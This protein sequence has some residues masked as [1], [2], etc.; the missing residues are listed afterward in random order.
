[1][2]QISSS[3]KWPR[4]KKCAL[5]LSL[6]IFASFG[7]MSLPASA[8]ISIDI[9]ATTR[10]VFEEGNFD[11]RRHSGNMQGVSFFKNGV[12]TMTADQVDIETVGQPTGNNIHVKSFSMVN[13][14]IVGAGAARFDEVHL[15]DVNFG[16][17]SGGQKFDLKAGYDLNI[18]SDGL[19]DD[20]SFQ[21]KG[22]E[23]TEGG[24][25]TVI[26]NIQTLGLSFDRLPDG[27]RYFKSA[28]VMIDGLTVSLTDID[29]EMQDFADL[30]R[31]RG[32]TSA[33]IDMALSQNA[34][35]VG[36]ALQ[37]EHTTNLVLRDLASLE[38]VSNFNL[39]FTALAALDK[40]GVE[41]IDD[42]SDMMGVLDGAELASFS[43][44]YLDNGLVDVMVEL[45]AVKE[46]MS[47]EEVRST[48]RY[49][50]SQT[51][52]QLLPHN[53]QRLTEPVDNL[54]KQG[55]GLELVIRPEQ[56]IP[57][58]S[59]LGFLIMPDMA[60]DQLGLELKHLRAN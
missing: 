49:M 9:D 6:G 18:I 55:G 53:G 2:T 25:S 1:M 3:A 19:S 40:A 8:E 13:G 56:P 57:L 47:V 39:S 36:T 17:I 27:Q 54:I 32:I 42:L 44:T 15:T 26:A 4:F 20:S 12:L 16:K 58:A 30:L 45:A 31:A 60:I 38:M 41:G 59:F 34:R 5:C 10:L 23:V 14:T 7:V 37:A 50:L 22:L 21:I 24:A 51:L 52:N 28:G 33:T 43:A 29:P 46:Q 11:V 48:A 35:I